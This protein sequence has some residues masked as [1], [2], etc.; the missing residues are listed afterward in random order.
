VYERVGPLDE[1]LERGEV[2][3][4]YARRVKEAG[5]EVRRAEDVFVHRFGHELMAQ[6]NNEVDL[7]TECQAFEL[8]PTGDVVMSDRAGT[9]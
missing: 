2:A 4:D 5:Y 8:I 9:R 6:V 1:Q 3:V 7:D